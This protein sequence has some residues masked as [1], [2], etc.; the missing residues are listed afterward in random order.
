MK[1]LYL[2]N[3][4][5]KVT[6]QFDTAC[7]DEFVDKIIPYD[8]PFTDED[9]ETI[10]D[11]QQENMFIIASRNPQQ[12]SSRKH[13]FFPVE[14]ANKG[15]NTGN[16]GFV[17]LSHIFLAAHDDDSVVARLQ[18]H[19]GLTFIKLLHTKE[20][21]STSCAPLQKLLM[22]GQAPD[23]GFKERMD[24]AKVEVT[25]LY[26]ESSSD[27][28]ETSLPIA[29]SGMPGNYTVTSKNPDGSTVESQYGA[30]VIFTHFLSV[31]QIEAVGKGF[32]MAVKKGRLHLL[33]NQLRL[34]QGIKVVRPQDPLASATDFFHDFFNLEEVTHFIEDPLIDHS[35]CGLC[36]TCVKT[37]LFHASVIEEDGDTGISTIY[38]DKCVA[39]GNCVTACPTEARDIPAYSYDY[40]STAWQQLQRFTGDANGLKILVIYCESNGHDAIQYLS[41][42]KLPVAPSCLFFKIRCGARLD[43]QFIPDSFKAGFDGVAVVVC[44]REECDNIVGSLDLE[45]RLNLYRKVLQ[46][47]NIETG[48]MRILPIA[49]DQLA[50]VSDSLQQFAL[51]LEN[52]K[53]DQKLFSTFLQ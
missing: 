3:E 8:P 43:T 6:K 17:D 12:S 14:L 25:T 18:I 7:L 41:D 40:F 48:R 45:R 26:L 52:L 5:Y 33:P 11:Q 20:C 38:A 51:Y 29:L 31:E 19:V 30:I 15:I 39:C 21:P 46:T 27:L 1:I 42:N 24:A 50:S 44:S 35:K 2:S 47:A 16:V 28:T 37:C 9:L 53:Q 49:S 10:V 22:I 4:I 23:G 32:N 36:G 13:G 34:S